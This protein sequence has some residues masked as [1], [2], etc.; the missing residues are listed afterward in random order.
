MDLSTYFYRTGIAVPYYVFPGMGVVING[1]CTHPKWGL[2][3][4]RDGVAQLLSADLP[5]GMTGEDWDTVLPVLWVKEQFLRVIDA[6]GVA[7]LTGSDSFI[8]NLTRVIST[9]PNGCNNK[10]KK[11]RSY[12]ELQRELLIALRKN[13]TDPAMLQRIDEGLAY[14]P[15][16]NLLKYYLIWNKL[17][18][19]GNVMHS[20]NRPKTAHEY[21][22]VFSRGA[23]RHLSVDDRQADEGDDSED[24]AYRRPRMRYY[25]YGATH[26]GT[27][28]HY[29][30][31]SSTYLGNTRSGKNPVETYVNTPLSVISAAKDTDRFVKTNNSTAKPLKLLEMVV[32]M[33]TTE[34]GLVVDPTAGSGTAAKAAMSLNRKFIVW[35][36]DPKQYDGIIEWLGVRSAPLTAPGPSSLSFGGYPKAVP[37]N[38]A[39]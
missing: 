21:I 14:I 10:G 9:L 26:T 35:E 7:A 36:R 15:T 30:K 8:H 38:K 37:P 2:A 1:D 28:E 11:E 18:Q 34:G 5:Y 16:E 24:D 25:P 13:V 20:K 33:F 32:G 29:K 39:A 12:E 4:L 22:A 17:L 31:G 23:I 3:N 19:Y 27:V 6:E